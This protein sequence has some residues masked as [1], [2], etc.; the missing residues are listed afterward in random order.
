M[1]TGPLETAGDIA[2]ASTALSGLLLVYMGMVT[3]SFEAYVAT[4][5]DFV[6]Q[7]FKARMRIALAGMYCAL[8]AAS[9]SLLAKWFSI[10]WLAWIALVAI[11]VSLILILVFVTIAYRDID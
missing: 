2:A 9:G 1:A 5:R 3:T 6:L 10:E 8:L 4:D 11:L 7:K